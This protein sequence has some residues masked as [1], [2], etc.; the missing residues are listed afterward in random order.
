MDSLGHYARTVCGPYR[1]ARA[2]VYA[3]ADDGDARPKGY[4]RPDR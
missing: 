4:R 1:Y 2:H 3:R